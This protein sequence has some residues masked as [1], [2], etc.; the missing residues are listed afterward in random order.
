MPNVTYWND[1]PNDITMMPSEWTHLSLC[2]ATTKLGIEIYAI[3]V[4]NAV[5]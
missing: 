2:S 1:A 5:L 4:N 3:P